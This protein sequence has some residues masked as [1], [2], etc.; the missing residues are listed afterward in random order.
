MF[1]KNG[2]N[3]MKIQ[4]LVKFSSPVPFHVNYIRY[5]TSS[6]PN[7]IAQNFFL[8]VQTT[9]GQT[10]FN[11]TSLNNFILDVIFDELSIG[12]HCILNPTHL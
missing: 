2:V 12:L 3:I 4:S 8:E 7:A 1:V 10:V 11:V 9:P 6:Y 5:L